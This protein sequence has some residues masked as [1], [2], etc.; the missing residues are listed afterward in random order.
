MSA[1]KVISFFG[2]NGSGAISI[3]GA[4]AGDLVVAV[5]AAD[6]SLGGGGVGAPEEGRFAKFI[7]ADGELQQIENQDRSSNPF[8]ALLQREIIFP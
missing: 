5:A 3:S 2:N 6:T 8:V 4:K 1:I 7:L